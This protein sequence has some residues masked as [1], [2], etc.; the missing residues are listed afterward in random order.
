[1][2]NYWTGKGYGLSNI[3]DLTGR[4]LLT[5]QGPNDKKSFLLSDR[6]AQ[7]FDFTIAQ[8][9]T[10]GAMKNER[11]DAGTSSFIKQQLGGVLDDEL[12]HKISLEL[13]GSN[14]PANLMIQPGRTAGASAASDQLENSLS[15]E[16]TAGRMSLLTAWRTLAE[17]KRFLLG[18]DSQLGTSFGF[19]ETM[20]LVFS[21]FKQVVG[22]GFKAN[23][24]KANTILQAQMKSDAD[25]IAQNKL[26]QKLL[27][28]VFSDNTTNLQ[29]QL[30]IS[31]T[32]AGQAT[33]SFLASYAESK[34]VDPREIVSALNAN[35]QQILQN[36]KQSPNVF[37]I[38][39]GTIVKII[40]IL[41]T[42][43][44]VAVTGGIILAIIGI[45]VAG[46]E[47]IL[48]ALSGGLLESIGA[49]FGVSA[50]TGIGLT[51]FVFGEAM[52]VA[53]IGL[54]MTVKQ[55]YDNVYLLPT[56]Q[57]SSLKDALAVQKGLAGFLPS[58]V[59]ATPAAAAP[60][61][62]IAAPKV[63][64]GIISQGTLGASVTFVPRPNDLIT[65]TTELQD[66][67]QNNLAP[68]LASLPG[69]VVY[70]IK[71]V[72]SVT[73]KDGFTQ[74]GT[75]QQ[76]VSGY[77]KDGTP[78]YRTIVNKFAVL[79]L[80]IVNDKGNRT[81]IGTVTLGPTDSLKFNPSQT[82]IGKIEIAV[83]TTATTS[84]IAEVQKIAPPVPAQQTPPLALPISAPQVNKPTAPAAPL[85]I[86]PVT[87]ADVNTAAMLG[88]PLDTY[89]QQQA[90]ATAAPA[91]AA[92][93]TAPKPGLNAN[94]LYE[95]YTANGQTLPTVSARSLI[96][97]GFGLGQ[98]S[99]YT[100][101]AEQNAKLLAALKA[102]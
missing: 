18:E 79:H 83:K 55:V 59:S 27:T 45:F 88:V 70:E 91:T 98:A 71:I 68:F 78:K 54:G 46:P 69:K 13:G 19:S 67:A 44:T 48:A 73:T 89:K 9:L 42:V 86:T 23:I 87:A 32:E 29:G 49:I 77:N 50:L 8:L 34:G 16:V 20:S 6:V 75:A 66:A 63:F 17:Q 97:A 14:T 96:Y 62:Y 64:T 47:A 21:T 40:G 93:A 61:P 12:D 30:N 36:S 52:T 31:Q 90:Q 37:G 39:S 65:N 3:T 33:K 57:I 15:L 26:D 1:M 76:V 85:V 95:W 72:S 2:A 81:K 35:I 60:K 25:K 53:S 41:Q 92:P 5:Y 28:K 4:P 101:T 102:Q 56:Q 99:Y 7:T 43:S 80:Y 58:A 51:S 38:P 84:N 82:D 74:R 11:M 10:P 24:N 22:G 100:G 94:T